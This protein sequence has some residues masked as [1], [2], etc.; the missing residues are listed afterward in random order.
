MEV[1]DPVL[2]GVVVEVVLCDVFAPAGRGG[3]GSGRLESGC[4]GRL[5]WPMRRRR[6]VGWFVGAS[7]TA[8]FVQRPGCPSR[9]GGRFCSLL[10]RVEVLALPGMAVRRLRRRL[11]FG[12]WGGSDRVSSWFVRGV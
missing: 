9:R 8:V 11:G 1:L 7:A 4:A 5:A 12:V 3:E 6:E 10:Q 2:D